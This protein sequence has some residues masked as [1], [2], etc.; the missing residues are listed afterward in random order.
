MF[1]L[2]NFLFCYFHPKQNVLVEASKEKRYVSLF[3]FFILW[4]KWWKTLKWKGNKEE[5]REKLGMKKIV[6][7]CE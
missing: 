6:A 7:D 5:D 2:R 1:K 3:L 4:K